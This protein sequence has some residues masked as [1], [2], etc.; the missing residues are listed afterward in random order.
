VT[1]RHGSRP[2]P[3]RRRAELSGRILSEV[4]PNSC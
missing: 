1:N 4:A 2:G 3:V